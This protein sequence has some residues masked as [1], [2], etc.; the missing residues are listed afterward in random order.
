MAAGF[1]LQTAINAIAAN[2]GDHFFISTVLAFVG[3]HDFDTPAARFRIA[4]VHTEQI[5]R[6][7][8]GFVTAGSGTHFDKR[9]AL[10]IRV[11]RQQQNLELLLHLFRTSFGVL[12]LFLRHF[13]HFRVVEHHLRSFNIFLNLAPVGKTTRNVTQLRIFARQSAKTI[14]VS[15]SRGIA[16]QGLNFFM[17]LVQSFQFGDDR[18]LHRRKC[19]L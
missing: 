19:T 3:A 14:L 16:E 15:N 2:F 17:A 7:Q 18:G 6:K 8:R 5:A 4:A 12:Q 10:I 1:K 11:F 9:I 13:A